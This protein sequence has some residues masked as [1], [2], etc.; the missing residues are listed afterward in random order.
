MH[1]QQNIK[2]YY[3]RTVRIILLNKRYLTGL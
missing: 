3:T 2:P 1:G